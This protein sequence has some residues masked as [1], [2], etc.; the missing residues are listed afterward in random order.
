MSDE[1]KSLLN[2]QPTY[3]DEQTQ[4]QPQLQQ[5]VYSQQQPVF[6]SPSMVS[7]DP[8]VWITQKPSLDPVIAAILSFWIPGLGHILIGQVCYL[9]YLYQ[10][11]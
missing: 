10:G 1:K 4:Q 11:L 8:N 9:G 7:L 3:Y 2:E 6:Q 5:P